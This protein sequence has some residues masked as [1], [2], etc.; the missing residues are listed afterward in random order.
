[1]IKDSYSLELQDLE[2][3]ALFKLALYCAEG[4]DEDGHSFPRN[5]SL[6][7]DL[8]R[9]VIL[10]NFLD[11]IRSWDGDAV[12]VMVGRRKGSRKGLVQPGGHVRAGRWC[13][14]PEHDRSKTMFRVSSRR[15]S[16]A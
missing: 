8:Y 13:Q 16:T 2:P 12:H 5:L 14:D 11:F 15:E 3:L 4:H 6:A 10:S 9:L 1:M 7:S